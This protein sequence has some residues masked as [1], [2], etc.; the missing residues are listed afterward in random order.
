ML[1]V[2]RP[3]IVRMKRRTLA[4]MVKEARGKLSQEKFAEL[5]GISR[6]TIANI[7]SGATKAPEKETLEGLQKAGL[8]M[9]DM[10]RAMGRLEQSEEMDIRAEFRRI[11]ALADLNE[12]IEALEDLPP[13][14][15]EMIEIMA[16]RLLQKRLRVNGHSSTGGSARL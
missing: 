16:H 1:V 5:T 8:S 11:R 2:R 12:Q 7:E 10:Y 3:Y 9:E 15:F 4:Q 13:D 14:L 6:S